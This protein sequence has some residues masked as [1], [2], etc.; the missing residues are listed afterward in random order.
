[1]DLG[2]HTE[3]RRTL[4]DTVSLIRRAVASQTE[5]RLRKD[6]GL[7]IP[8]LVVQLSDT[9]WSFRFLRCTSMPQPG[10]PADHEGA[11]STESCDRAPAVPAADTEGTGWV[12]RPDYGN[13]GSSVF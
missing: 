10:Q 6:P 9:F 8:Y 5:A 3:Q 13:P 2:D 7:H 1:M 12:M 11:V 4:H